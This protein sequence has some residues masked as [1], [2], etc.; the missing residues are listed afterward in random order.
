MQQNIHR[1]DKQVQQVV[2]IQTEKNQNHSTMF[3][4]DVR[5]SLSGIINMKSR[6]ES[7]V[8]LKYWFIST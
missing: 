8:I 2:K 6:N 4:N 7:Q 5:L 1:V 3:T